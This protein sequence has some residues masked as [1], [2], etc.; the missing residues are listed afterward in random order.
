M[1]TALK[2]AYYGFGPNLFQLGKTVPTYSMPRDPLATNCLA[3]YEEYIGFGCQR[4]QERYPD[5]WS[6]YVKAFKEASAT[7]GKC[8]HDWDFD[9]STN[10]DVL[11]D[12][13][14]V[15]SSTGMTVYAYPPGSNCDI[16]RRY[17]AFDADWTS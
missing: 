15:C 3:K 10:E 4:G 12:M 2:A 1:K 17:I 16:K 9:Y 7:P 6:K 13:S 8:Q 14:M 5:D 11:R